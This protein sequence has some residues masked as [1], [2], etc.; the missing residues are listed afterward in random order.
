[1]ILTRE[2]LIVILQQQPEGTKILIESFDGATSQCMKES[3]VIGAWECV[4]EDGEEKEDVM[5]FTTYREDNKTNN[6]KGGGNN[7][8]T[9]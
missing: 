3:D 2:R 4:S 9:K 8:E 1:M 7:E 5:L 6:L